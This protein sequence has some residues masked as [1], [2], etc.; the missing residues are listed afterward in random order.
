MRGRRI[1][2]Q[3]LTP[4]KRRKSQ[5]ARGCPTGRA[6]FRRIQKSVYAE[7][8]LGRFPR[9]R[10]AGLDPNANRLAVDAG[11][12]VPRRASP[13]MHTRET[14]AW[15]PESD[16]FGATAKG[17]PPTTQTSSVARLKSSRAPRESRDQ[18]PCRCAR[19]HPAAGLNRYRNSFLIGLPRGKVP[20]GTFRKHGLAE[21]GL[22]ERDA[23]CHRL[24]PSCNFCTKS[25]HIYHCAQKI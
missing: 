25:R 10:L 9:R 14:A 20:R 11:K 21:D 15:P 12:T 18:P 23:T 8:P 6:R 19:P 24:N 22:C 1:G 16:L 7:N 17:Q 2:Q 5:T 4:P 13:K 3:G